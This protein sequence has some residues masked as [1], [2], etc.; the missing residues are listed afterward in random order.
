MTWVLMMI[1]VASAGAESCAGDRSAE[2]ISALVDQAE[3][4]F[5]DFDVE[6]FGEA[7]D[8]ASLVLP[9]LAEPLP[10][11]LA[12]R[13]HRAQGLR[14]FVAESEDRAARSFAAARTIE[15]EYSFPETLLPKGHAV[16]QLYV[17][18]PLENGETE[19]LPHPKEGEL[20]L[21]GTAGDARPMSWPVI[22]QHVDDAGAVQVTAYLYPED[23][24]PPYE[25]KRPPIAALPFIKT[26]AQLGFSAGA[27][28]GAVA[29]GAL[30]GAAAAARG[31]FDAPHRDW[32]LGQF[33]GQQGK[34]NGLVVAS[35]AVGV[36]A[37][38]S[39]AMAVVSGRW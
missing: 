22:L 4:S 38:G 34:T 37:V 1:G 6:G 5:G 3:Q 12:A 10:P 20:L 29:A 33:Q 21:D 27:I 23:A 18:V 26:R 31:D 36:L 11:A 32:S 28:G 2:D 9:C 13:Y 30:Y 15:P 19:T 24:L 25:M 17:A 35:G 39:G 7:L 8:E 14:Q 16:R